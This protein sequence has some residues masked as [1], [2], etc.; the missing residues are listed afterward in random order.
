M[1]KYM[2]FIHVRFHSRSVRL[3]HWEQLNIQKNYKQP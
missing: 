3:E 1:H 2:I